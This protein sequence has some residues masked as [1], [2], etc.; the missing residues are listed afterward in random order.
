MFEPVVAHRVE[1]CLAVGKQRHVDLA[2]ANCLVAAD[3]LLLAAVVAERHVILEQ[4]H[5]AEHG[6]E[7]LHRNGQ[8]RLNQHRYLLLGFVHAVV[9]RHSVLALVELP[10]LL[11]EV[12]AISQHFAVLEPYLQQLGVLSS[13][14]SLLRI[15]PLEQLQSNQRPT[16]GGVHNVICVVPE[17]LLVLLC[18]VLLIR[19]FRCLQGRRSST[20]LLGLCLGC[21]E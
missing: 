8:L 20:F 1:V 5:F 17:A 16:V 7:V 9:E 6:H 2:V 4:V 3:P 15:N 21:D 13:V 18:E 19:L 14:P 12:A 11:L 10:L